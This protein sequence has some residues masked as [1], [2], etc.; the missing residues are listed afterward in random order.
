MNCLDTENPVSIS[1]PVIDFLKND[2]GYDGLVITD[3]L[4]MIDIDHKY[5]EALLAGVDIMIVDDSREATFDV[6]D[7][8]LTGE[9]SE[10]ELD[11]HVTRIL[12]HKLSHNL[13]Q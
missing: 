8:V 6:L 5:R 10:E 13:F 9:V 2:L 7:A 4:G 12:E 3:S 11:Y 1:K